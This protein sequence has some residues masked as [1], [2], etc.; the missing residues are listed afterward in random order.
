MLPGMISKYVETFMFKHQGF[1]P[2]KFEKLLAVISKVQE[3]QG[4]HQNLK[5][6]HMTI[7][8]F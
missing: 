7:E 5:M 1:K 2:D 6:C 3:Y 4:W 8:K